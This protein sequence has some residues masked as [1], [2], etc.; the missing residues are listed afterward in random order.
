MLILLQPGGVN[1]EGNHRS[2]RPITRRRVQ[3]RCRSPGRGRRRFCWQTSSR[4]QRKNNAAR[5]SSGAKS[6]KRR[7]AF[8]RQRMQVWSE[9]PQAYTVAWRRPQYSPCT[10]G[11]APCSRAGLLL[12]S[13]MLSSSCMLTRLS[14]CARIT[15][16]RATR[17][18]APAKSRSRARGH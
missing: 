14:V 10:R 2:N 12:P 6:Q 1:S 18:P 17:H 7:V 5:T 16:Q 3:T 8:H 9:A 13:R 4:C 15:R 11:T